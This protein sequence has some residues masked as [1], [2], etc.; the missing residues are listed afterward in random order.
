DKRLVLAFVVLTMVGACS[1]AQV[2]PAPPTSSAANASINIE[3]DAVAALSRMNAYLAELPAFEVSSNAAIDR[4][5]ENGVR[6]QFEEH[7]IYRLRKPDAF[8]VDVQN[9]R[10]WRQYFYDGRAL[11][12]FAPH[13]GY[14]AEIS[15]PPSIAGALQ[16]AADDYGIEIPFTAL[17]RWSSPN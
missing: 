1:R 12:M 4:I 8:S 5:S 2:A 11:A 17:L 10:R 9:E 7:A 14:Y 16:L 13:T 15:A 3:A 6:E